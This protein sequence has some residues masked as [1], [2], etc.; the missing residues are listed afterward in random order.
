MDP[1]DESDRPFQS[2]DNIFEQ[3]VT[4]IQIELFFDEICKC[5][6][7]SIMIYNNMQLKGLFGKMPINKNFDSAY[8]AYSKTLNLDSPQYDECEVFS[9]TCNIAEE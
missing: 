1:E 3:K 4:V 9:F 2:W 8:S 5:P 7:F 6:I